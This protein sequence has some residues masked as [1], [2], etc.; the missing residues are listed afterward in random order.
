M[1]TKASL[2]AHIGKCKIYLEERQQKINSITKDYLIKEYIEEGKSGEFIAKQIGIKSKYIQQKLIEFGIPIRTLQEAKKLSHH[3]ELSKETS[4]KKYGVE[5]NQLNKKIQNKTKKTNLE[6]YGTENVFQSEKIKN[7]IKKTNLEKY[8]VENPYK[9]KIIQDKI[10]KTNLEKYGVENIS[11]SPL[12]KKTI[13][14]SFKESGRLKS[15]TIFKKEVFD[16][17]GDKIEVLEEYISAKDKILFQCNK[18]N[19]RFKM[20]PN[21]FLNGNRCPRCSI[22]KGEE[23]IE[24]WLKTNNID[25]YSQYKFSDCKNKRSLPFDF[26]LMDFDCCIE[27]DGKQHFEPTRFGSKNQ[28]KTIKGFIQILINDKIKDDFCKLN[29]I[30][31]IRI[32]YWDLNKIDKILNEEFNLPTQQDI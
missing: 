24:K 32:P 4:L 19:H 9:S 17:V 10:K 21:S 23:S 26:Y 3:L 2:I 18:C 29:K 7:K 27:F 25:F 1:K 13:R 6:K 20:N 5:W 11:Q 30:K 22:S 14:K 15:T 16:L 28:M 8:D 12:F 31:L